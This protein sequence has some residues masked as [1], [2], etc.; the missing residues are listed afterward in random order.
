MF[1]SSIQDAQE[2]PVG[3]EF[4]DQSRHL[5]AGRHFVGCNSQPDIRLVPPYPSKKFQI[6]S[7][8]CSVQNRSRLPSSCTARIPPTLVQFFN[9]RGTKFATILRISSVPTYHFSCL[10]ETDFFFCRIFPPFCF[11]FNFYSGDKICNIYIYIRMRQIEL[12]CVDVV[13]NLYFLWHFV[14][15]TW[16]TTSCDP[17]RHF[18]F[19][20]VAAYLASGSG[21]FIH[22]WTKILIRCFRM[23]PP[24]PPVPIHVSSV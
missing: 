18:L 15:T 3:C 1:G 9:L 12:T 13:K 2:E 5:R 6:S 14:D 16:Q 8:S 21:R 23:Y 19:V 4:R 20:D 24:P 17:V 7:A 11:F 22:G 10:P